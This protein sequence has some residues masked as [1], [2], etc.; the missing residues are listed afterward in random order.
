M[1][2][3]TFI[4]GDQEFTCQRMN[5]FA[6]NTL[7]IRLQKIVV[8]VLGALFAGGKSFAD[9]DVKEAAQLI[10]QNIDE[11]AMTEIVLPMFAESKLFAVGPRKFIK[12]EQDVNAVFTV[13]TLFDFYE[14]VWLVGKAQFSPFFAAMLARFGADALAAPT[15]K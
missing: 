10:A 6:A 4:V 5:A 12:S 13:D 2:T 1:S 7:L 3:Q 14:L 9:M 15:P 8:P 11:R